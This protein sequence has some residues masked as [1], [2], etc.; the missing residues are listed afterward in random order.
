MMYV[1]TIHVRCDH[2][3]FY[4][5][6]YTASLSI[7]YESICVSLRMGTKQTTLGAMR[8]LYVSYTVII[9]ASFELT[10]SNF[11]AV[12]VLIRFFL[13]V[14]YC[15][16]QFCH[17]YKSATFITTFYYLSKAIAIAA[18]YTHNYWLCTH[19]SCDR[20]SKQYPAMDLCRGLAY[21]E[22]FNKK[23]N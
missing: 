12:F 17:I 20:Y 4:F 13:L 3:F 10:V 7:T 14:C 1:F 11:V 16:E 15:L 8:T 21:D 2:L 22:L 6:L 9:N 5:S 19:E 23:E 18:K